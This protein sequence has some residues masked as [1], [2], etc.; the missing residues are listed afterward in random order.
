[1]NDG[2]AAPI[3]EAGFDIVAVSTCQPLDV[4]SL[5]RGD[6]FGDNFARRRLD[7]H[8]SALLEPAFDTSDADRQ[9]AGTID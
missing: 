6:P 3:A 4:G 7:S 8:C 5:V 2:R 1:M 9:Q